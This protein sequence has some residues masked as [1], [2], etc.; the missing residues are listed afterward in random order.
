MIS[1][2]SIKPAFQQLLKP[3]LAALYKLGVSANAITWASVFLSLLT[4]VFFWLH[5]FGSAFLILPLALLLRMALNA[6][7]GMMARTYNMASRSG[8]VLNEIGDVVSDL[9]MFFPFI[10]LDPVNRNIFLAFLFLS[11]INEYAGILAKAVS[12]QRRYDGPMGK[13]DRAL[14]IGCVSLL[15]FFW[16]GVAG[17]LN[18][19]FSVAVLLLLI[20]TGLRIHHTLK[21]KN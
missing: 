10:Q 6:L 9:F 8:E 2:Y 20:S 15:L 11:V 18:I 7:D 13:S 3:V 1:V 14:L 5:P 12:G 21:I 17:C 19:I 16:P 4:G